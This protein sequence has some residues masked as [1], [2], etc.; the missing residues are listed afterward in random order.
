MSPFAV[1]GKL[2]P[3]PVPRQH[4]IRRN[5]PLRASSPPAGEAG[6]EPVVGLLGLPGPSL[7]L[8]ARPSPKSS[9]AVTRVV[10][11]RPE[12]VWRSGPHARGPPPRALALLQQLPAR[13][14]RGARPARRGTEANEARADLLGHQVWWEVSNDGD[15]HAATTPRA[16]WRATA[17]SPTTHYQTCQDVRALAAAKERRP[18]A[19]P[20]AFSRSRLKSGTKDP[21]LPL[22][23]S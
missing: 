14:W 18:A 15:V 9:S 5:R 4:L 7:L 16:P 19:P 3:L 22:A 10:D 11:P 20:T 6:S 12:W 17:I 23:S 1:A 2:A 8:L 13:G 21:Q